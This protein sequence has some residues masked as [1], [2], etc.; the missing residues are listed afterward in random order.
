[1]PNLTCVK[2][3]YFNLKEIKCETKDMK[4]TIKCSSHFPLLH[5]IC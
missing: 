2:L 4:S 3:T 1:M 5:Y